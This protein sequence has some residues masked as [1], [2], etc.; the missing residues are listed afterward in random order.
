MSLTMS[1]GF[2]ENKDRNLS[3]SAHRAWKVGNRPNEL[4]LD[5]L[6]LVSLHHVS[7]GS[8]QPQIRLRR[9]RNGIA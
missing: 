7:L 8:W 9:P 4:K 3:E 2:Q 1:C 5:D 6:V